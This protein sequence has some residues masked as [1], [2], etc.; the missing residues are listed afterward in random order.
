MGGGAV[1][2]TVS[3]LARMGARRVNDARC[4]GHALPVGGRAL[5]VGVLAGGAL[6]VRG[7]SLPLRVRLAALGAALVFASAPAYA[8]PK[9][10]EVKGAHQPSDITIID[11]AGEPLQQLRVNDKLRVHAWVPLTQISPALQ[12]ALIDSEDKRF[13]DHGGVDWQAASAAALQNATGGNKRGA[14]TLSMQLVGLLDDGLK[15]TPGQTR[16]NSGQKLDQMAGAL[17]L[18]R[19]WTKPHILEAYLNLVPFRGDIVGIGAMSHALFGK[20]PHGLNARESAIAAALVRAPAAPAPQVAERACAL[21]TKQSLA[22]DGLPGYV[23][24]VMNRAYAQ[25]PRTNHAPHYGRIALANHMANHMA[26]YVAPHMANHLATQPAS[27]SANRAVAPTIAPAIHVTPQ[28]SVHT[29][30]QSA[31]QSAPHVPPQSAPP[32]TLRTTLDARLQKRTNA[33]LRQRLAELNGR[34]VEDG[35]VVVLDNAS[36]EVLAYV[37]SSGSLSRAAE[38]DGASALRQAGSTLK[39][40]L[41][42][43]AI[44]EKRLTAASL[45]DDSPVELATATGLYIPRNYANDFKGPVSVRTA[46]ASSLNI[47]AVRAIVMTGTEPFTQALRKAGLGTLTEAGDFYGYSLALGSADVRLIDLARAYRTLARGGIAAD[48]SRSFSAESAFIVGDILADRTARAPTFGFHSVLETPYW[49]AVKTGTSKDM[50]DNW[51]VGYS[52]RYTVAVWMGNA[53][54]LPMHDV[55]G[56]SGAAPLWRDLMDFLHPRGTHALTH[57]TADAPKPPL[58]AVLQPVTY[59][60]MIEATRPEWFVRGTERA[61]IL[62]VGV[63]QGSHAGAKD[64]LAPRIAYPADGAIFALDPD[65]PPDRQR[66]MLQAHGAQSALRGTYWELATTAPAPDRKRASTSQPLPVSEARSAAPPAPTLRRLGSAAAA[67]VPWLPM[68]GRHTLAL[69]SADGQILHTVQ[70]EVRGAF[71][72]Q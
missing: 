21:L 24:L 4:A 51:A 50:R 53:S 35:A 9:F 12:R 36:G 19:N 61:E 29:R 14:S 1:S 37:G 65:I 60:P 63:T 23:A 6:P 44:D 39:P 30:P 38:V 3:F 28:G 45:L 8:L 48:G 15:P 11:R 68:P 26:S 47:P 2:V 62:A 18:E 64:N 41:Y 72:R 55:S 16:R 31:R 42:A 13:Y 70:L 20:E 58:H 56:V 43:L 71:L 57:K 52:Q 7:R 25:A 22:C 49:S 40:F 34:N 32:S 5:A 33:A 10:S 17:Q 54:G 46:L 67:G 27:P 66:V 59:K 69:K